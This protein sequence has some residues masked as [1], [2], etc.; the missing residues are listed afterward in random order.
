[1]IGGA[2]TDESNVFELER[3][4]RPWFAAAF[5][6][7]ALGERVGWEMTFGM[8]Q[9]P[10]GIVPCFLVYAQLPGATLGRFHTK[11]IQVVTLGL[12]EEGVQ[13]AVRDVLAELHGMRRNELT[14]VNHAG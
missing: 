6:T 8:G 10:E 13:R 11:T 9:T 7:Q 3:R 5:R 1:M 4:I 14:V 2:V 12:T